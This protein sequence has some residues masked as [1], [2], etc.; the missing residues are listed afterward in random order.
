M[1]D[2]DHSSLTCNGKQTQGVCCVQA[3]L[4]SKQQ[5]DQPNSSN[6]QQQ[7]VECLSI[8]PMD[9]VPQLDEDKRHAVI[10]SLVK[11]CHC[12]APVEDASILC[13]STSFSCTS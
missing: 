3:Q 2:Y 4:D 12:N 9:R 11:V 1:L 10:A 8:I 13:L 7:Q 5:L 6:K